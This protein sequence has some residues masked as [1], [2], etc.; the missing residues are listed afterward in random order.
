MALSLIEF[1]K[2]AVLEFVGAFNTLQP[3]KFFT[4]IADEEVV[5]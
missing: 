1:L 4:F 2:G 5:L 3:N